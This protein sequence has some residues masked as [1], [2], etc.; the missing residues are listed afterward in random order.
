MIASKVITLIASFAFA[1]LLQPGAYATAS[2]A[3]TVAGT[4]ALLAP[5]VL[6]DLLVSE[7]NLRQM[8]IG[9]FWLISLGS[10]VVTALLIISLIP[11]S[12]SIYGSES[13]LAAPLALLAIRSL[14]ESL[15]IVPFSKLR[16]ALR[17]REISVIEAIS[18]LIGTVFGIASAALGGGAISLLVVFVGSAGVRS[19]LLMWTSR[20]LL[21]IGVSPSTS[22]SQWKLFLAGAGQY[23]HALLARL[24]ILV[25]G[26][27]CSRDILGYYAWAVALA[28][29]T[30]AVLVAQL[31]AILQ[32][33]LAVFETERSRQI[34]AHRRICRMMMCIGVPAAFIQATVAAPL[35]R[36][37]F[38][39]RWL[40][41]V[42]IFVV[43]SIHVALGINAASVMAMLKARGLFLEL[44]VWQGM[45]LL[46]SAVLFSVLGLLDIDFSR[47][48][49]TA[50]F[51]PAAVGQQIP[52]AIATCNAIVWGISIPIA[53]WR[54]L[55]EPVKR[56]DFIRAGIVWSVAIGVCAILHGLQLAIAG[57]VV[58]WIADVLSVF[59]FAPLAFLFA[60]FIGSRG[61][62]RLTEDLLL[63]LELIRRR[64]PIG[65]RI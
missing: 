15:S 46:A 27:F 28:F 52:L 29:Q 22:I 55:G 5:T 32:P 31:G 1:R 65:R 19:L 6:S 2:L 35:I 42:P 61:D 14:L 21:D 54:I 43:L 50:V 53:R 63:G 36:L 57:M 20:R 39:E 12:S 48:I 38:S 25:I 9:R 16:I 23:V 11:I 18:V 62:L 30:Q 3:I 34:A 33:V 41:A 64:L 17:F 45:Q 26:I 58:Q 24:D 44:L 51:G 49:F 60:V 37:L 13:N 40:P 47:Q 8:R 4:V 59:V 56:E 7:A 10:G